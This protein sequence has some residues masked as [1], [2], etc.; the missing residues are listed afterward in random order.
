MHAIV[1]H[2]AVSVYANGTL[3]FHVITKITDLLLLHIHS[4]LHILE[5]ALRKPQ[6]PRPEFYRVTY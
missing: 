6:N 3:A 4:S 1:N 2:I 5:N